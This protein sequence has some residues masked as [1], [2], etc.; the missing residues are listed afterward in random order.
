MERIGMYQKYLFGLMV[1]FSFQQC[2]AS[3][4]VKVF[5]LIDE[6]LRI[7]L[8]RVPNSQNDFQLKNGNKM[9]SR[10]GIRGREEI[11]PKHSVFFNLEA[12]IYPHQKHHK[13]MFGRSHYLGY[14]NP[15]LGKLTLGLQSSVGFDIA[16]IFDPSGVIRQ[17]YVI[18]DL[19]GSFNGRYGNKWADNALKYSF[20]TKNLNLL[21]SYQVANDQ[22]HQ[23]PNYAIGMSYKLGDLLMGSS[24]SVTGHQ[25]MSQRIGNSQIVNAGFTYLMGPTHLKMGVAHSQLGDLTKSSKF[26]SQGVTQ[27]QNI[28]FGF[29]H[30]LQPKIDLYAGVYAQK[31]IINHQQTIHGYKYVFGSNYHLSKQTHLYGFFHHATGSDMGKLI[32]DIT[33]ASLGLVHRF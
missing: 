32:P 17:K 10:F 11:L 26:S 12:D 25:K 7:D 13:Q 24:F 16:R 33:S 18:D 6:G 1:V 21:S 22:L 14:E 15:N 5:G 31:N 4:E 23:Q 28:G 9:S 19:S 8:N 29:K 3:P 2:F 30:H 20:K 27:I